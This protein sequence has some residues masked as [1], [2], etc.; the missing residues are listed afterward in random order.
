[1]PIMFKLTVTAFMAAALGAGVAWYA[2]DAQRRTL[3]DELSAIRQSC[4]KLALDLGP[5]IGQF[6]PDR[7]S[8]PF[9]D[10]VTGTL[11][12]CRSGKPQWGV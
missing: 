1:M 2:V 12:V 10:S 9:I 4:E 6:G 7:R 11:Q 8:R 3:A 5:F